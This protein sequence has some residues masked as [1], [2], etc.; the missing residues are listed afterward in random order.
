[1]QMNVDRAGAQGHLHAVLAGSFT[2]IDGGWWG[3]A[4]SATRFRDLL[5]RG[6]AAGAAPASVWSVHGPPVHRRGVWRQRGPRPLRSHAWQNL[7]RAPQEQRPAKGA[8]L[9]L[10]LACVGA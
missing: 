9:R 7:A 10:P 3:V 1:M 5:G 8:T 6:A 4:R 2:S